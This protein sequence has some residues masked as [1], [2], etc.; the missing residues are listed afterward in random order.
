MIAR[1]AREVCK[2]EE[3]KE[4]DGR[5][6]GS[7]MRLRKRGNGEETRSNAPFLVVSN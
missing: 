3:Q 7:V 6:R 5:E 2:V 1:K 4:A